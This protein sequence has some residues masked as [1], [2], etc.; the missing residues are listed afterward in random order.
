VVTD[1]GKR[2]VHIEEYPNPIPGPGQVLLRVKAAGICGSDLQMYHGEHTPDV[3]QAGRH[4]IGH[5][6]AGIVAD[7]GPG[8][9]AISRG[10]RLNIYHLTGCGSCRYCRQDLYQFC[11]KMRKSMGFHLHGSDADFL[12]CDAKYT[13]PLP[14]SVSFEDSAVA[15]CVGGTAFCALQKGEISKGES[16]AVFGLGPVGLSVALLASKMGSS[17]IGLDLIDTRLQ[18]GLQ[19]GCQAVIDVRVED[20]VTAILRLTDGLGTPVVVECSGSPDAQQAAIQAAAIRG[21]VILVG[22]NDELTIDPSKQ[23]LIRREV[24]LMGSWVFS[25][26]DL[27]DLL[28]FL[29]RERFSFK[30]I[31][32]HHFPLVGAAEAFSLFDRRETGKVILIP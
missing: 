13:V 17:V 29:D 8:V 32:T 9:T 10:D 7:V 5:E 19:I 25:R 12:C 11:E 21:R 30:Q 14:P 16:V 6:A 4:I 1:F 2:G 31:I 15:A 27:V 3:V 20:P 22:H 26:A 18:L 23:L 28:S 24:S